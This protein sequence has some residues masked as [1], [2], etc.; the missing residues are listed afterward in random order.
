VDVPHDATLRAANRN[1]AFAAALLHELAAHGV[2]HV[3]LCPGSR[4]APL[5]V[6]SARIDRLRCW[7]HVDERSAAFFALG[8]AQASN[9]PVATICTSGSAAANLLPAVVEA[10]QARVPLL[11][12]TADRPPELRGWGA[13]QTIDQVHLYGSHVR[14]F[15]DAPCPEPGTA[16]LAYARSLAGRAVAAATGLPPGPV[17]LN[18]PFREPLAPVPVEADAIAVDC[19]AQA[20][21]RGRSGRPYS[22]GT[23]AWNAPSPALVA[24]LSETALAARR[25]V[26]VCGPMRPGSDLPEAIAELAASAGW[27]VLADST[28]Q[29]RCGPHTLRAPILSTGDALLRDPVFAR[30]AAPDLVVRFGAPPTSKALTAWVEQHAGAELWVVD[31]EGGWSDPEHRSSEVIHADPARLC[32]ALERRLRAVGRS[33]DRSWLAHFLR[34]DACARAAI[35]SCVAKEETLLEPRLVG[36]IADALPEGALLFVSN[37]MPVRDLDSFLA[38]SPRS[39]PIFANRGANG[40]DGIVSTAL[41]VGAARQERVVLLTGDLALLHDLTAL[42]N[43]RRHRIP[44]TV[45][46]INNEGG[47][48]FGFLPIAA[49]GEE[50]RFEELFAARH[51]LDLQRIASGLGVRAVRAADPC[52]FRSA[53]DASLA[54]RDAHLIEVPVDRDRSVRHHRAIWEEVASALRAFAP[55]EAAP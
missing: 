40:I 6:A 49:Y 11:L 41:G 43:G 55:S 38:V 37:S 51:D 36:E 7:V 29:L 34:A 48:I 22:R 10:S 21:L 15:A 3:C 35:E 52:S 50:V 17:H 53:F 14:W 33:R 27:P 42:L 25:G 12:L 28:S 16:A 23:R 45:V 32:D 30:T 19:A 39:L 5:A 1:H 8:L 2:H 13:P 46:V 26:L 44:V 24:R 18:L 47:G 31:G 20:A 4:S 54:S 9:T